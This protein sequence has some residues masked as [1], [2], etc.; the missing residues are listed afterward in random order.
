MAYIEQA[1][2][3]SLVIGSTGHE[4][5]SIKLFVGGKERCG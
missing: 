3:D 5:G 4:Y 1:N 2:N